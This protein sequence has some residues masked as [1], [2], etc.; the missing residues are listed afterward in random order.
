MWL[1]GGREEITAPGAGLCQGNER[2]VP[3]PTA[4]P[5][6]PDCLP[7][8]SSPHPGPP[9]G[10]PPAA[11][12]AARFA[13][14]RSSLPALPRLGPPRRQR[15]R[16]RRLRGHRLR[17]RRLLSLRPTPR[18]RSEVPGPSPSVFARRQG[19]GT[20]TVR[21]LPARPPHSSS[22]SPPFFFNLFSF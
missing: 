21:S 8:L 13:P 3:G 17:H 20:P 7:A 9:A 18:V 12:A 14:A 15:L 1:S 5:Q 4:W 10:R 19:I 22:P 16:H 6:C 2:A 11:A